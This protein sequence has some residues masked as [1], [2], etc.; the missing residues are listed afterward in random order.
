MIQDNRSTPFLWI[1][2][3]AMDI[4]RGKPATLML[5]LHIIRRGGRGG[6]CWQSIDKISEDLGLSPGT[7]K[8]SL[9]EL[10]DLGMIK[11]R[12]R[13]GY[14]SEYSITNPDQWGGVDQI[15]PRGGSNTTQGGGS[16]PT[17][18]VDQICT[19][20]GSN[21]T[22]GVD[23]IQPRGWIKYDPLIRSQDLDPKTKEDLSRSLNNRASAS[24]VFLDEEAAPPEDLI[25]FVMAQ[26]PG[27]DRPR[28]YALAAIARDRGYWESRHHASQ[29][30]EAKVNPVPRP[31]PQSGDRTNVP[32]AAAVV[33]KSKNS[34]Q[35][36]SLPWE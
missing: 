23:Q 13:L 22:Q 16:N 2:L 12:S 25:A 10:V 30:R 15:Q 8:R 21:T 32:P 26:N 4:L 33:E 11:R 36:G 18:G 35:A 6:E 5:Y 31:T 19:R 20:G 28:P 29:G 3:E 14:S 7:V 1:H 9:R 24:E 17:Q 27:V 34:D